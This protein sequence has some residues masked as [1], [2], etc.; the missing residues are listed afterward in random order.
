MAAKNTFSTLYKYELFSGK[1]SEIFVIEIVNDKIDEVLFNVKE[2][3]E[4]KDDI[5]FI[6]KRFNPLQLPDIDFILRISGST[7]KI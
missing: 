3:V 4:E 1:Y 6:Y 5:D 2:R 7:I